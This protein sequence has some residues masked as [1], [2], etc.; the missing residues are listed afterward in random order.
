MRM[1]WP[2]ILVW[3]RMLYLTRSISR[4][5]EAL[6]LHAACIKKDERQL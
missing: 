5:P 3:T 6:D 2:V 4:G 1:T